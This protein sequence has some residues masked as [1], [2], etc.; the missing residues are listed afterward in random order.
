MDIAEEMRISRPSVSV[1]M[2]KLREGKFILVDEDGFITLT[3]EGAEI[4]ERTYERFLSIIAWLVSLG[5]DEKTAAK[6]AGFMEHRISDETFA[7]LK[8]YATAA[9]AGRVN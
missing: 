5:V 8:V 1:A 6:D 3:A 2:K 7:A 9:G 4:A